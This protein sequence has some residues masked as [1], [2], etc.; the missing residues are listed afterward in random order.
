MVEQ[1]AI[2]GIASSI[3]AEIFKFIPALRKNGLVASITTIVILLAISY[4]STGTLTF[5]GF[6]LSLVFALTTYKAV[7]QPVAVATGS[8]TQK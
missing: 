8:P 7:V 1:S 6:V 5:D 2:I 4:F 3:V